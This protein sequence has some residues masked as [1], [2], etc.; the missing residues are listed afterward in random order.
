MTRRLRIASTAFGA[1][2]VPACAGFQPDPPM[3]K[4]VN[5]PIPTAAGYRPTPPTPTAVAAQPPKPR[6]ME[7]FADGRP[8]PAPAPVFVREPLPAIDPSRHTEVT[9]IEHRSPET[10][11]G[12]LDPP[13]IN[14]PVF[15]GGLSTPPPEPVPDLDGVIRTPH[16]PVIKGFSSDPLIMPKS[17]PNIVAPPPGELPSVLIP[18]SAPAERSS[19]KP[20]NIPAALVQPPVTAPAAPA[21]LPPGVIGSSVHQSNASPAGAVG[22]D[23][24][25]PAELTMTDQIP[26]SGESALLLAVRACQQNKPDE[27]VEYLKSYDPATQQILLALMPALVRFSEGK[28]QQMKPEEMDVLLEQLNRVPNMLRSRA[29][30]QANNVRLCREV[31]NFAHVEPF[32]DRHVF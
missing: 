29:S 28:L 24:P 21:T 10:T 14:L 25:L 30:L 1:M 22:V 32:P 19:L 13:R 7:R 2:L 9:A 8:D 26:Q 6:I 11:P 15:S 3:I 12:P 18:P 16:W 17:V 31:H 23:S 5:P 27:A 20:E 4:P